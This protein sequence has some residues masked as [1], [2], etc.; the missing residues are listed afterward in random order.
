MRPYYDQD[1]ITIFHGDCRD[2]LPTL[3][4]ASVDLLITDPPYGVK[5]QSNFRR[6]LFS[7]IANDHSVDAAV[8]G[9]KLALRVLRS[10]RHAYVFGRF[11]LSG[12]PATEPVELIWDKEIQS[13]GDVSSPWGI[14]HEYIQF[15]VNL[16][17]AQNKADGKGKLA[18]R[19]RKGSVIRCQRPNGVGVQLHP[20]EKPVRL[21]REL[22]ESSPASAS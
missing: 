19:L 9:V 12:L 22:I 7:P 6:E 5:W 3:D 20:T 21:I 16:H 11:N 13:G 15:L 18:A 17:S 10:S 14:E 4:P 2:V 1:G 8:E